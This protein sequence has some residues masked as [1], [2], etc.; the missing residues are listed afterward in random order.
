MP[1]EERD[2]AIRKLTCPLCGGSKFTREEGKMDSKWGFTA[3]KVIIMICDKCQFV[4]NFSKGRS[5]WDFD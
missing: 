1:K 5:I 3:H 4:M 2:N